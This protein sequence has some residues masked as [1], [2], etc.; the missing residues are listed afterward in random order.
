MVLPNAKNY[1][2]NGILTNYG[3][4]IK[5]SL[6]S[7][8]LISQ[9][10]DYFNVK[11]KPQY[12]D[13]EQENDDNVAFDV[14]YEDDTYIAIPKFIAGTSIK[15][16]FLDEKTNKKYSGVN[17][18]VE[19]SRYK[20]KS[21][22]FNFTG[23]L[24]DYQVELVNSITGKIG[25]VDGIITKKLEPKG[26]IIQLSVGAGKCLALD[27]KII[28]YDGTI[29]PVQDIKVGDL[30]M[31]DDSSP[32]TVLSL[33]CGQEQMYKI[34]IQE[35]CIPEL[36]GDY[37]VNESHILSL[38]YK[39]NQEI[40]VRELSVKEY[41]NLSFE[42]KAQLFGYRVEINFPE[43]HILNCP[44]EFGLEY[45]RTHI[46]KN[47]DDSLTQTIPNE[48]I[49]NSKT[50]RLKFL[51]GIIDGFFNEK[52]NFTANLN[53]TEYYIHFLNSALELKQ[54]ENIIF[55]IRTLGFNIKIFKNQ[56][57]ILTV[58]LFGKKIE[59]LP[60]KL[61]PKKKSIGFN[62]Q[63]ENLL[64]R[65][66]IEKL[67]VDKYYG[68]EIDGNKRFLLKDL[69][70]THNTVLAIYL[71]HLLKLKTL[72]IVHQEFLQDQWIERFN[73]FTN[74]KIGTIR[75]T[76]ID[77]VDKDVVIGMLQSISQKEYSDDIFKEFGLVIYDEVHHFG[78][79]VFSR[80]LMKTSSLYNIGL[81]ATPERTDGLIK[82]VKWFT[83][84]IMC[85][86]D[87]K[88]SYKVL[89]KR[90]HF[91]S[92]DITFKEKR[93]WIKGKI[94]PNHIKMTEN[95][96]NNKSRNKLMIQAI[97]CLKS[98]GRTIFVIS[99]RVEHLQILKTG[100][101]ALILSAGEQHIYNTYYYI[102]PTKKGEKKLAEKDGNIIFATQQLA[103]EALDIP[104]LDTIILALPIKQE[105]TLV[106]SIGRILRNDKLEHYT[107]IPLVIDI[108]D[109]LSIYQGW[110]TK[111][112]S[113]YY[114]KNWYVQ[115]YYWEDDNLL[116][117]QKQNK[118]PMNVIFDD[119]EDED[120]IEKN[121]ILP[122]DE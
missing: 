111:R 94:R 84:D 43:T 25:F 55:V 37:V 61:Q 24:R 110:G 65:F 23:K 5:K 50:V 99:S 79:R 91:R 106:Q 40:K 83:G 4:C 6:Y 81:S 11:P 59:D 75:G 107:Q 56:N 103:S 115:N 30:L 33:G 19:K 71:A 28:M 66:S 85:K 69:T 89:V 14:Y 7:E 104:R 9:I 100:V 72:I 119:V 53:K 16:N 8:N 64:Y 41:L 116:C 92:S 93:T 18:V 58:K 54:I 108:S 34:K 120:F 15:I 67:S 77:I 46:L 76:V 3:L 21:I 49:I 57:N 13:S 74:A 35:L 47:T 113:I 102:G 101:D 44:Y 105:K 32:R 38:K 68:F 121:L 78:S 17:F 29:K 80:A 109:I 73:M 87:K 20:H 97:N 60:L 52:Y 12:G 31:G 98:I 90:I 51:A 114:T 22:N 118:K 39:D 26:G 88:Y 63:E 1:T 48:Y 112:E 27:T 117:N 10:R 82:V 2:I 96:I 95:L 86:M 122:L 70:V 45:C 42:E 62:Y 36:S